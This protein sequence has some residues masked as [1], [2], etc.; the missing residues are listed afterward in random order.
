MRRRPDPH[1]DSP[2]RDP[3][4]DKPGP[5]PTLAQLRKA[6]SWWWVYC[7]QNG[8]SHSAPMALVPLIIRWGGAAS[9]DR[10]RARARCTKCGGRGAA[11]MHPSYVDSVIGFQPFPVERL[12]EQQ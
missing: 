2:R 1:D 10:L 12:A 6:N 3:R 9:S 4:R 8:C 5:V 11:L 7:R